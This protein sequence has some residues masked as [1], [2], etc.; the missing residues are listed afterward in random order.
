[1]NLTQHFT[2]EELYASEIADRNHIDNTPTDPQ[3]LNNLKSLALNLESVR[4]L[5]GYPI[6]VNSAYRCLLVNGMLGSKATSAHVRG[7]AADIVCPA[8]GS[9]A[10]IVNAI[11]ASSIPYDQVILEYDRWC[12][13]G[14]AE[15]GKEPRLEQ[16]II[17]KEGTK[18]YGN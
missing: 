9:P 17:D 3:I 11:I 2:F 8:F 13:I 16:L 7:L 18:R 14:F 12:H 5:L 4:R 1:M 15:E 6:H 10:D